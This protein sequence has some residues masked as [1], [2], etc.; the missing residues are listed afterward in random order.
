MMKTC[1]SAIFLFC[2]L[3][4]PVDNE[5]KRQRK[6]ARFASKNLRSVRTASNSKIIRLRP[7]INVLN[8]LVTRNSS[9]RAFIIRCCGRETCRFDSRGQKSQNEIV[10][11]GG[12]NYFF[13]STRASSYEDAE[14]QCRAKGMDLISLDSPYEDTMVSKHLSKIGSSSR[15]VLTATRRKTSFKYLSVNDQPAPHLNFGKQVPPGRV[16]GDCVVT[17]KGAM[18]QQDCAKTINFACEQNNYGLQPIASAPVVQIGGREYLFPSD[19]ASA[20]DA[21]KLCQSRGMQ[22]ISLETPKESNLIMDYLKS[23]SLDSVL[24]SLTK[25]GDNLNWLDSVVADFVQWAPNQ[26]AATEA[27]CGSFGAKG[28]ATVACDA[29]STFACEAD[30]DLRKPIGEAEIFSIGDGKYLF[31]SDTGTFEEAQK[32]CGSRDMDLMSLASGAEASAVSD[33]LGSLGASTAPVMTSLQQDAGGDF[34]WLGGVAASVLGWAPEQPKKGQGCAGI[35]GGQFFGLDCNQKNHF[36]CEA[37]KDDDPLSKLLS[38]AECKLDISFSFHFLIKQIN[39]KKNSF[40]ATL[41][42]IGESGYVVPKEKAKYDDASKICG[43][44]DMSLASLETVAENDAVKDWLGD[45]GLSSTAI[46]TSLKKSGVDSFDWVGGVAAQFLNWAPDQ[47]AAAAGDCATLGGLGLSAA[48]CNTVSNFI[49]ETK[50]STTQAT[51]TTTEDPFSKLLSIAEAEVVKLTS[52]NY[53]FPSDKKNFVDAEAA[54]S[55]RGMG[56]ASLETLAENDVVKDFLGGMG[57]SS[58]TVLTSLKSVGAGSFEWLGGIAA[59]FLPAWA[60]G[61]APGN[62]GPDDGS[63]AGV[64]ALGLKSADCDTLNH[65][66]C[67][68]KNSTTAA[69]STTLMTPSTTTTTATTTQTVTTTV[70]TTTTTTT[71]TTTTTTIKPALNVIINNKTYYLSNETATR[72]QAIALCLKRNQSLLVVE[73]LGEHLALLSALLNNS[74]FLGSYSYV[75]SLIKTNGLYK[76]LNESAFDLTAV[77][78]ATLPL[79]QDACAAYVNA[80]LLPFP[81]ANASTF[82]CEDPT[83]PRQKINVTIVADGVS[84]F[85]SAKTGNLS[86]AQ[87]DCRAMGMAL[88]SLE[89]PAEFSL[90]QNLVQNLSINLMGTYLTSLTTVSMSSNNYGL[91]SVWDTGVIF[92]PTQ[93]GLT[94]TPS[95]GSC[96]SFKDKVFAFTNCSDATEYICE[97][98]TPKPALNV[99]LLGKNYYFSNKTATLTGQD[100]CLQFPGYALLSIESILERNLVAG[101]LTNLTLNLNGSFWTSLNAFGW[102]SFTWTSKTV[103]TFL[104]ETVE[105]Q[106]ANFYPFTCFALMQGR[107]ANA[108]CSNSFFFIC[109]TVEKQCKQIC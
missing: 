1:A 53:I 90:L 109:E 24:T 105:L 31:P 61:G 102:G 54:C 79:V 29:P 37:K 17:W 49:C 13:P 66:L 43:S 26:P 77:Q 25:K 99:T 2:L 97:Q 35:S 34:S 21:A 63:C 41:K 36:G 56:L 15:M 75:T 3:L 94:A 5:N 14:K 67:E 74:K 4:T 19:K 7:N 23:N 42:Q 28:M 12:R 40:E 91:Q 11:I 44:R 58:Q 72:E 46:L 30:K 93:V 47:P 71:A 39:I 48:D 84:Y 83:P 27:K 45:L 50:S 95:L 18:Y 96:G 33:F 85:F 86:V 16:F 106:P 73:T 89:T 10:H 57:L 80:T 103:T 6:V 104:N 65:F 100:P 69:P 108:N 76:W 98:T 70:A 107:L 55:T 9:K 51:T 92:Y 88:L 20:A 60:P 101:L 32:M 62:G 38:M 8:I 59:Q 68:E 82:I 87:A 81:C 78:W 52:G 22:L 64:T